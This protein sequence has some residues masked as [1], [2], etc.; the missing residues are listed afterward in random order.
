MITTHGLVA[1]AAGA[2]DFAGKLQRTTLVGDFSFWDHFW[3][4]TL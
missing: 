2:E 1:E 3:V 4:F